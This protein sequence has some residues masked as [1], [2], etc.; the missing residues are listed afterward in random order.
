MKHPSSS[1]L[2]RWWRNY[3]IYDEVLGL[4]IHL[5][6][7]ETFLYFVT[8]LL[9]L[10]EQENWENYPGV[11]LMPNGDNWNPH[12]LHF[13]EAQAAMMDSSG[14]IVR[15][16][17]QNRTLFE[18]TNISELYAEPCMWD[19]FEQIVIDQL[20]KADNKSNT[21][22]D[23]DEAMLKCDGICTQLVSVTLIF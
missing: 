19:S 20:C 15:Q 17:K 2:M 11:Y 4:W 21:L 7:N 16:K 1:R 22:G 23:D 18:E 8:Q 14:E 3:S 9:T 10:E 12:V 5:Q 13:A 6:L